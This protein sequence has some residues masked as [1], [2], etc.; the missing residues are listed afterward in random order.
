M[1][2]G[3]KGGDPVSPVLPELLPS[4]SFNDPDGNVA[5]NAQLVI[6]PD[7]Q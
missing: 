7:S 6:T 2:K 5:N 1:N 3:Q 4:H